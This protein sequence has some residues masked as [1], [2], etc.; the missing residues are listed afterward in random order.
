[1]AVDGMRYSEYA[2]HPSASAH[3]VTCDE[4]L[5]TSD[6]YA[7]GEQK[8]IEDVLEWARSHVKRLHRVDV[9]IMPGVIHML[10]EPAK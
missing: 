2:E 6:S 4:H 7:V 8:Y 10:W 3:C 5:S 1:M 9:D